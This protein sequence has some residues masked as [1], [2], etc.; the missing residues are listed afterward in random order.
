VAGM[1]C[2]SMVLFVIANK[3]TTAANAIFLQSS[4]PL[5]VMVF[6]AALLQEKPT[7]RDYGMTIVFAAG[8]ACFFFSPEKA[9]A[10]SPKILLGNAIALLS[11][12]TV[13]LMIIG[14]RSL[15]QGGAVTAVAMGNSL[16]AAI[17]LP[18]A[19]LGLGGEWIAGTPL[20]WFTAAW[21]GVIQIGGGIFFIHADCARCAPWRPR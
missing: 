7:R 15:R 6:S 4:F 12:L 1:N 10:L 5:W 9:T 20:D 14:F 11:G 17:C 2:A 3:T 19:A 13:A 18:A 8:L 21:L 16:A